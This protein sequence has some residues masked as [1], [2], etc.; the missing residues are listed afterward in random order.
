MD[1]V[2]LLIIPVFWVTPVRSFPVVA[3]AIIFS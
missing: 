2:I 1:V 3:S